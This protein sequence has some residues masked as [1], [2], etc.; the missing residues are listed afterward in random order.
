MFRFLKRSRIARFDSPRSA[1]HSP[2]SSGSEQKKSPAF[3][4][5][6]A[7]LRGP[8]LLSEITFVAAYSSAEIPSE[9]C[10]AADV[11]A[12]GSELDV[13]ERKRVE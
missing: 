13:V 9:N 7:V 1:I 6:R 4:E 3:Q 2:K 8:N 5:G 11:Q 12:A 10:E